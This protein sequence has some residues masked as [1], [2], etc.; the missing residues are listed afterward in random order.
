[1]S[2]DPLKKMIYF[3]DLLFSATATLSA[4]VAFGFLWHPRWS[5]AQSPHN[6]QKHSV[7][8]KVTRQLYICTDISES[9]K[10]PSPLFMLPS[11]WGGLQSLQLHGFFRAACFLHCSVN[12]GDIFKYFFVMARH[13]W[14]SVLAHMESCSDILV[15]IGSFLVW[16]FF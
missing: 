5:D 12:L 3:A 1:M 10:S 11:I 2:F 7:Y 16:M 14:V 13:G 15:K 4:E 6:L 8:S 9:F